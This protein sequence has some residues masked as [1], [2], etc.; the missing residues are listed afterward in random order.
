MA[1]DDLLLSG[2]S[3]LD[4]SAVKVLFYRFELDLFNVIL[5]TNFEKS[6]YYLNNTKVGK[7]NLTQRNPT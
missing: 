2:I 4:S 1:K 7:P 3:Y 6:C 5:M